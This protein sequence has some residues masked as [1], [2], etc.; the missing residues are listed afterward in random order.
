MTR[1]RDG[2]VV[3]AGCAWEKLGIVCHVSSPEDHKWE[4]LPTCERDRARIHH[5][6][7]KV[8]PGIFLGYALIAWRIWKG[9]ILIADI[10][11]NWQSWTHQRYTPED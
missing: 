7:K 4:Y 9:D 1:T 10:E 8:L 5:F 2:K 3:A 6:G 11:K